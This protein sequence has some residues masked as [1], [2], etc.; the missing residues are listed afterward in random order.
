MVSGQIVTIVFAILCVFVLIA[1]YSRGIKFSPSNEAIGVWVNDQLMYVLYNSNFVL[2]P[3]PSEVRAFPKGPQQIWMGPIPATTA[4]NVDLTYV[5]PPTFIFEVYDVVAIKLA[6]NRKPALALNSKIRASMMEFVQSHTLAQLRIL[7]PIAV[8]EKVI[9][10]TRALGLTWGVRLIDF[11]PGEYDI[12]ENYRAI[13][14]TQQAG[15]AQATALRVVNQARLESEQALVEVRGGPA[16][17]AQI[18]QMQDLS[19]AIT[20]AK[21][22]VVSIG[23]SMGNLWNG[24]HLPPLP[25][26]KPIEPIVPVDRGTNSGNGGN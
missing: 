19:A 5:G 22:N 4:D 10:D 14:A 8:R 13:L 15:D 25:Q 18:V 11:L 17:H 3:F 12:G 9:S 6:P 7:G 24:G 20:A 26:I 1:R 16:Y 2:V 23:G 21:P